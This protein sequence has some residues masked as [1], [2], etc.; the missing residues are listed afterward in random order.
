[1]PTNGIIQTRDAGPWPAQSL[2]LPFD[3]LLT[4]FSL[5]LRTFLMRTCIR[6]PELLCSRL[7]RPTLYY[8]PCSW[9][10][11]RRMSSNPPSV[12]PVQST[13]FIELD[14]AEQFEEEEM[15]FTPLEDYYPVRIGEVFRSR[16]QVVS[17]LG[18]RTKSTAW[19]CRDLS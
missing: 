3:Y 15:L 18:F 1:M 12:H 9:L 6:C 17:K 19:L 8:R 4:Y 5:F 2:S 11:A 7:S 10:H 16:Y 13:G 14:H